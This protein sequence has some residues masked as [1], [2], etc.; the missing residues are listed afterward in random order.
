MGHNA[1]KIP[2]G[3]TQSS[4]KT[5][6]NMLGAIDA[7]KIVRLKSDGTI[8][9]ALADGSAIGISLGK[10]LS[11]TS[12]TAICRK[13]LKVPIL[14]TSGFSPAIGAQVAI[15]D[16]T[17]LAK[18]YTGSGDSYVNATYASTKKIA[19]LEDGTEVADGVAYIDM[20]GGL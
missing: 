20:P 7:G 14:L 1:A 8:S 15:S 5:V 10:S 6:D 13:G 2:M 9:L 11:D 4:D 18:A 17:G 12:R 16:T 3:A 19:V